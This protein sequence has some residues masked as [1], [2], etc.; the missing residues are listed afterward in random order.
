MI[1]VS[2]AINIIDREIKPLA[3]ELIALEK[4]VGRVLAENIVADTDMPPF[5]RSQMDGFAVRSADVRQVPATLKLVGESAAGRG[6]HHNLGKG[7]TIRIMTG[8]PMPE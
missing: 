6:W 4:A 5:D 1:P 3:V 8:A 7:E 2:K